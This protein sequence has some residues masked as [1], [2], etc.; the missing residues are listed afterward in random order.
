M[1]QKVGT[2]LGET[3]GHVLDVDSCADKSAWEMID[4]T[5]PLRHGSILSLSKERNLVVMFRYDKLPYFCY[6]CGCLTHFETECDAGLL[7]A[8]SPSKMGKEHGP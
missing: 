6:L 8:M 4:V 7:V 2:V 3:I 1:N 5:I